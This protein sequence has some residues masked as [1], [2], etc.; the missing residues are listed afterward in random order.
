MTIYLINYFLI[1]IFN[2]ITRKLRNGKNVFLV[3]SFIL[4]WFI[5]ILRWN[6]GVDYKSYN[7]IYQQVLCSDLFESFSL[8]EPGYV[9]IIYFSNFLLPNSFWMMHFIVGTLTLVFFFLAIKKLSTNYFLST[10][11]FVS[12][13]F[14]YSMMNQERQF[15]AMSIVAYSLYYLI[16]KKDK[17]ACFLWILIAT[18]FHYSA[19]VCML[20]LLP[21]YLKKIKYKKVVFFSCILLLFIFVLN[22]DKI[23][24]GT[25]YGDYF[26]S[27]Y[28]NRLQTS[29]IL[30]TIVRVIICI[31][32]YY[33][34]RLNKN[35]LKQYSVLFYML[36]FMMFFQI[37]SL[38]SSFY[39]RITTY[40]F[41][42]IIFLIPII[43]DKINI[44]INKI[45]INKVIILFIILL[46]IPY[47][48]VYFNLQSKSMGV[49]QYISIFNNDS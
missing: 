41:M 37:C 20:I 2:F 48:F 36:C 33:I 34:Y 22:L 18:L 8:I 15:L 3:L 12:I 9:I 10:Y 25:N 38:R 44:R 32:I 35:S 17:V 5:V 27:Y 21:D 43:T 30:N 46:L 42:A 47:H 31:P 39:G 11:I 28:D 16:N 7:Q 19:I 6:I 4:M 40:F 1:F 26:N 24:Y 45:K 14:L 13:N 49:N 29:V 23:L